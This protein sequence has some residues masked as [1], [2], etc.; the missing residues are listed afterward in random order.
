MTLFYTFSWNLYY[1]YNYSPGRCCPLNVMIV[2]WLINSCSDYQHG[3]SCPPEDGWHAEDEAQA[4]K[5]RQPRGGITKQETTLHHMYFFH[6][7]FCHLLFLS[8]LKVGLHLLMFFS[9][10][11]L[12]YTPGEEWG[13]CWG[14]TWTARTSWRRTKVGTDL[15]DMII[16]TG[17][18]NDFIYI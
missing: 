5:Q 9:P 18:P 7:F 6:Y 10:S 11:S 8:I 13:I 16:R 4:E 3:R 2:K 17:E 14:R 1:Y 12:V 15:S